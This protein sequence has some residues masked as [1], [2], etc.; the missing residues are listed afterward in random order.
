MTQPRFT[1]AVVRPPT[2]NFAD[3][4]TTVTLG[5]P[6]F[7]CALAQHA[8]YVQALEGCGLRVTRA[9]PDA[10]F[11]DATF[12]EDTA[13]ITER[14]AI[15]ARPGA[16]SRSGEVDAIRATI[17]SRTQ[18]TDTI[19]PPGTVDGGDICAAGETVFIGIS[20]RTNDEGARQL[21]EILR[22]QG[23]RTQQV[24]I[25]PLPGLLHLKSGVAWLGGRRLLAVDVLAQHPAFATLEILTVPQAEAY[26]ANAVAV[27]GRGLLAAGYPQTERVLAAAEFDVLKIEVSEFRKMDGGLS[28]LS[29]RF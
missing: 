16:A 23:Y 21:A 8:G 13:I 9:Q 5:P 28:C 26:A 18:V 24:D 1:Q 2:P 11:P 6:D 4:L 25:R 10:R 27:N 3:G 12:V 17:E 19:E 7:A 22:G 14:G 20:A 29:L 15:L